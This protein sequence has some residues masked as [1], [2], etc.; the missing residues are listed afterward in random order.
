MEKS[1]IFEIWN[2]NKSRIISAIR[3]KVKRT[4]DI[5]DLSHDV[6]L[7]FWLR[8]EEI[9]DRNKV[10]PWLNSV[11][12]NTITDFYRK[13]ER[14][15]S[16]DKTPSNARVETLE[17]RDT[18]DSEKLLPIIHS[19]P[20]KYRTVLL[21]S[22]IYGL[23]HKEISQQLDLTIACIKTRVIRARNLLVERMKQCC[24]F[25]HDKYGNIIQCVEKQAYLDWL[26]NTEKNN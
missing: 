11:T 14:I 20:V 5:E 1:E 4:V 16:F 7:K 12:R 10:L 19:L 9:R 26:D 23:S 6:F 18:D 25:T 3:K 15:R 8:N 24:S 13:K 17:K 2:A 22:D 21:M